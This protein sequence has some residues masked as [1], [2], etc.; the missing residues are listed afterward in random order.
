MFKIKKKS[1]WTFVTSAGGSAG[2]SR[3]SKSPIFVTGGAGKITL[4]APGGSNVVFDYGVVGVG[5]G[6]KG[7]QYSFAGSSEDNFSVGAVYLLEGCSG[8]ELTSKD[9]EGFC[10]THDASASVIKGFSGTAMLL[11]I[12]MTS[13]PGELVKNTGAL[14]IGAQ[15]AVD[16]PGVTK[17]LL[18]PVAAL[19]STRSKTR[20][21]TAF[22]ARPKLCCSWAERLAEGRPD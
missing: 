19:H 3:T 4:K 22:E 17:A 21:T 12:P 8:A 18:G 10:I 14:G 7:V 16:H 15:L 11:G 13:V 5:V 6:F 2:A 1:R 20:S 9:M